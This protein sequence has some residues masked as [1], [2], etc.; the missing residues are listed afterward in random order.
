MS[1]TASKL[2]INSEYLLFTN[3]GTI[4]GEKVKVKAILNY[5]KAN[6]IPFS[7]KNL[8]IN[9]KV[10]DV[11]ALET[12]TYIEN[13]LYYLC[14]SKDA[15]GNENSI[16]VWDDVIDSSKT[17]KLAA[18]YNYTLNL[19]VSAA[20]I[21]DL[22]TIENSITTFINNTYGNTV[23]PNL[24]ANGEVET[25][26][27]PKTQELNRYK[28]ML[29]DAMGLADKMAKLKQIET[30]INYFA[31]DDMYQKIVSMSDALSEIQST[32]STISA[33]IS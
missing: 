24:V 28:E 6:E 18:E 30:L 9:E 16:L 33:Q 12:D 3:Y 1:G 15:N 4:N 21:A 14:I 11:T 7:I 5:E 22:P 20:L 25:T 29:Q 26:L 10:I 8:A 17:T 32:I 31:K 2:C 23:I 27:D 13:Q 19:T